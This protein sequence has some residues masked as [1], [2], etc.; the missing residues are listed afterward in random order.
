[1]G[2]YFESR[3]LDSLAGRLRL[4][5]ACDPGAA[6]LEELATALRGG[7]SAPRP[8]LIHFGFISSRSPGIGAPISGCGPT[9]RLASVNA[10]PGQ[11]PNCAGPG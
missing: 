6:V 4:A 5:A 11:W 7:G 9:L 10:G 1:M 2:G 8:M 3:S